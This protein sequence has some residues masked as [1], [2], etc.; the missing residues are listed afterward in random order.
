MM[1]ATVGD[2]VIIKGRHLGE[3]EGDGVIIALAGPDG[4]PPCGS[5]G[6]RTAAS[7]SSSPAPTP[8]SSTCAT[9]AAAGRTDG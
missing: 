2:R 7:A 9:R 6:R 8:L 3:P 4:Q 5:A 1:Q